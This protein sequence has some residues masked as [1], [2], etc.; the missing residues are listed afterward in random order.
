MQSKKNASSGYW[1]YAN[2]FTYNAAGAVTSMQLGNGRWESTTFNSRLQPTQ[3]GLGTTPGATNLLDLDYSYGT[4]ANSGNVISQTI[5]VPTVG[6]NTGFTAVQTY[7]Y[8]SSQS[9]K[10]CD[11]EYHSEGRI[12]DAVV[13]TDVHIRSV[14]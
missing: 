8:D 9:S 12:A 7:N 6:S 10:G 11:G 4:T 5:T 1:A 2:S 3:I 13:E 14:W